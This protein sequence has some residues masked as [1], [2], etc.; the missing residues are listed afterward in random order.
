MDDVKYECTDSGLKVDPV[1]LIKCE[2]IKIISGVEATSKDQQNPWLIVIKP[3]IDYCTSDVIG[4]TEFCND[5]M[6]A[7]DP[8]TI[9][10]TQRRI[11]AAPEN[12]RTHPR[13]LPY[14][15]PLLSCNE[16]YERSDHLQRHIRTTT[17]GERPSSQQQELR[18]QAPGNLESQVRTR[19][20]NRPYV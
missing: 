14:V 7:N 16:R 4:S 19:S 13:E 17:H 20:V 9:Y 6:G 15:C 2:D 11:L 3:E 1:E 12:V 5:E 18:E 10:R 8:S